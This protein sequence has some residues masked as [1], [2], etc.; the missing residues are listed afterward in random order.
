MRIGVISDIHSNLPALEGFI[1]RWDDLKIDRVVCLG[2][3][4]GYNPWPN[5]CIEIVMDRKIPAIMGNH[6]RVAAG[7]EEPDNFNAAAKRAIFWTREI[8]TDENRNWLSGLPERLL[9]NDDTMLVHGSP[10]NPNEYIFSIDSAA[11]NIKY[12]SEQFGASICFFG[13]THA[14]AVYAYVTGE[15]T[16]LEGPTIKI[17][18]GKHYLINPGSIGQPRDGDPRAAFII[19]DDAEMVIEFYRYS[20]DIDAVYNAIIEAGQDQF[21]GKR[22]FLG[23]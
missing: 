19:F 17:E 9:I 8:L 15:L 5:E 13:H 3:I 1:A 2:D 22:L 23:R 16:L 12:M 7:I 6:D 18:K 20:Y 11:Y 4:V 14:V 10:S 21:L